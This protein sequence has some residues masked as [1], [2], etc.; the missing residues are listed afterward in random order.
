MRPPCPLA[1]PLPP[2]APAPT[3]GELRP[4]AAV[5][6]VPNHLHVELGLLCV[7]YGCHMLVEKP[8]APS[9]EEGRRLVEAAEAAGLLLVVGHHRRFDPSVVAA[10]SC[11]DPSSPDGIGPLHNASVIWALR[12]PDEYYSLAHRR[13]KGAG[14]L[15]TNFSHDVDTLRF[16]CGE[17]EEVMGMSTN[18]LGRGG[19][20]E[21][22]AALLLRFRSGALASVS[23]ADG[24]PSPCKIVILSRFACCP[25]R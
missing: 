11:M 6:A 22:N 17:I 23:I 16:L 19:E 8:L 12:K 24:A 20:N 3:T 7:K 4:D 2:D 13:E 25:S 15:Y 1:L 10:R 18:R 21:D 5:V 14:P 9:V